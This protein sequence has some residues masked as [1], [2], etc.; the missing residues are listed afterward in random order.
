MKTADYISSI[1]I[2]LGARYTGVYAN[3]Y[4]YGELPGSGIGITL[5]LP[6]EGGKMTWSQSGRIATRHRIR[7]NKRRKQAKRLMKLVV[8]EL[9]KNN[10]IQFSNEKWLSLWEATKGV[11]NR[12]GYNR[13]EAEVDLS[14]LESIDVLCNGKIKLLNLI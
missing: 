3:T 14:Y 6:E 4:E 2:D 10:K 13:I 8:T 1:N 9:L 7:S 12:R 5:C 11:L